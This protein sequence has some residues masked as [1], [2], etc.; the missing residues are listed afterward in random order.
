MGTLS[1]RLARLDGIRAIAIV[2]VILVHHVI[3][4]EFGWAGVDLF[5]VLSGLLITRILRASTTQ[6]TYWSR[7]YLKRAVRIL[8][9]LLLLVVGCVLLVHHLSWIG[10]TGYLLFLGNVV[11]LTPY[12]IAILGVLWSLAVEEHFY[13]LWPLAV[14]HLSRRRLM[15]LLAAVLLL[16]PV[17]RGLATPHLSSWEPLYALTPF[18]LDSIAAGALLALL[19]EGNSATVWLRRWS[20]PG[21]LALLALYLGLRASLPFYR[22]ANQLPFNMFGYSLIA[23]ICFCIVARVL[24]TSEGWVSTFLAWR[25]IAYVG[26][27]SYGMYLYESIVL[28]ALKQAFHLPFATPNLRALHWLVPLDLAL[29]VAVAALSF[30]FVETPI[31]KWGNRMAVR[32]ETA[33]G[34]ST[35][36]EQEEVSGAVRRTA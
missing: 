12:R 17:L 10:L 16:E 7:F 21:V 8:P 3:F 23:A 22:N 25:P 28:T 27:I 15:V 32:K 33:A 20:G 19:T 26:R 18:H 11:N 31:L 13:L 29:T 5:F 4:P 34:D 6:T 30:H 36:S 24:L 1:M 9:P 2:M 35:R 14:K